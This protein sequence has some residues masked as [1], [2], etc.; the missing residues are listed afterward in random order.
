MF[1]HFALIEHRLCLFEA[2]VGP[3]VDVVVASQGAPSKANA[4]RSAA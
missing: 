1:T 2:A 3:L 4:A